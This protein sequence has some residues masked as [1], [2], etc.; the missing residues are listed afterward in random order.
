MNKYDFDKAIKLNNQIKFKRMLIDNLK[1]NEKYL[2]G[3]LL[4]IDG[5]VWRELPDQLTEQIY[6]LI[7]D[8]L[9]EQKEKLEKEFEDL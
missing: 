4:N 1:K 6:Y 8:T 5:D 3:A 7:L 9:E 2:L